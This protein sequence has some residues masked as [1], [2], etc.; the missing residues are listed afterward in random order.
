LHFSTESGLMA[1]V[2]RL[3]RLALRFYNSGK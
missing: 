3:D 2:S 1:I